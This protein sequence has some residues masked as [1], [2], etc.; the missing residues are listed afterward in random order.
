MPLQRSSTLLVIAGVGSA[1]L[2]TPAARPQ[3]TRVAAASGYI[4]DIPQGAPDAILGIA[5]AFRESTAASLVDRED[6]SESG[7]LRSVKTR[8]NRDRSAARTYGG[9]FA[10]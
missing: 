5:Q 8:A 7:V 2:A 1:L 6:G 10:P 3:P 4:A 9:A